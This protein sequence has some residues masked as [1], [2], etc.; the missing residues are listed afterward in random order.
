MH[1][2]FFFSKLRYFSYFGGL[3]LYFNVDKRRFLGIC[4]L[5][6]DIIGPFELEKKNNKSNFH[7]K[8]YILIFSRCRLVLSHEA[9]KK[10]VN[11]FSKN[12]NIDKN[13]EKVKNIS[14]Q[15]RF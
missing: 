6:G 12:E 14:L 10:L 8:I 9:W 5:N 1:Y 4:C 3:K 15:Q 2:F 13:C 11:Y 7:L